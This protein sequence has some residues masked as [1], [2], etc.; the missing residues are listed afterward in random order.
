MQKEQF[1][2]V[3]NVQQKHHELSVIQAATNTE[4]HRKL[5]T[6]NICHQKQQNPRQR[7]PGEVIISFSNEL[8]CHQH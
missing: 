7:S 2:G 6:H 1:Y 5:Q 3:P 8:D 4:L